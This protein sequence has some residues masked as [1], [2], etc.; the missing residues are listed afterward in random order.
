MK[1]RKTFLTL[2]ALFS[3]LISCTNDSFDVDIQ[4]ITVE[5]EHINVDS[6]F[7]K[8]TLNDTK[9]AHERFTNLLDDL[10]LYEISQ[11][12]QQNPDSNSYKAIHDFYKS[13]YIS[14]IEK[15][16]K[17]LYSKLDPKKVTIEKGFRYLKHHFPKVKSPHFIIYMNKLFS[18]IHCSDTS[19]SVGL[20]QYLSPDSKLIVEIPNNQLYEWQKQRMNF[21]FLERDLL[22]QWIQVH[23]F[24]AK[25]G[26]LAEHIVQAGKILYVLNATLPNAEKQYILRYNDKQFKWAEQ[27]EEMTWNYLVKEQL[28]FENNDRDKANFLN[29]GPQT[30]GLPESSPDRMGQFLGFQMVFGYMTKN[31]DVSLP[32][33]IETDY[34]KILQTYEID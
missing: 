7:Y 15:V 24:E 27:N 20:E 2:I 10:Y 29:E 21:D 5:I 1:K 22:M 3:I 17:K 13:E 18:N 32:E 16:K 8:A 33:L 25:D 6:A 34:N 14:E 31:K 11:N 19:V 12:I 9:K 30:I 26:K 28:L 4:N 23:L